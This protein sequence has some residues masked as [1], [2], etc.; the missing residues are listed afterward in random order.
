MTR[1]PVAQ[2]WAEREERGSPT[3]I[4]L[5]AWLARQLGRGAT[6]L[7][8]YPIALYFLLAAPDARAASRD[9]LTRARG[10]PAT[11]GQVYRHLHC[12]AATILDRVFFLTGRTGLFDIRF[13]GLDDLPDA[14]TI[15]A[16]GLVLTGAHF[17]SFDAMRALAKQRPEIRLRV[18]MREG[19]DSRIGVALQAIAPDAARE[20]IWLGAPDSM[21]QVR[22]WLRDGG[23][24]GIL[25]DRTPTGEKTRRVS[26]LGTPAAFPA[27]PWLLTALTGAPA[28]LFA[29]VY[30]GENRYRIRFRRLADR[31]ERRHRGADAFDPQI[32]TYAAV[33]EA[34]VRDNPENWFNFYDFWD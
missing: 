8:L 28:V 31:V 19:P 5:I 32:E 12:F 6:R 11:V 30:E 17:G 25:A 16:R 23:T 10:R 3:L 27:A 7:L 15:R 4:R 13:D 24:V 2:S 1:I 29:G 14:G 22:E 26:F 9:A 18:L 20:I 34:W 21:L 33:L